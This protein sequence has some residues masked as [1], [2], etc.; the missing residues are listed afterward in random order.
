MLFVSLN[1]PLFSSS[2]HILKALDRAAGP[3]QRFRG[4]RALHFAPPPKKTGGGG[5]KKTLSSKWSGC[6]Y[7]L[8]SEFAFGSLRDLLNLSVRIIS[9]EPMIRLRA[10][11]YPLHIYATSI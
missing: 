7:R 6:I 11:M 10:Y 5:E 8:S 4:L 3:V 2:V 9:F 1:N